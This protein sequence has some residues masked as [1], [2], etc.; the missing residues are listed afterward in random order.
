M[1]APKFTIVPIDGDEEIVHLRPAQQ[2]AYEVDFDEPLFAD[3]E[4]VRMSKV[5]MLAWYA[6]G[7]PGKFKDWLDTLEAVE[8]ADQG[9]DQDDEGDGDSPT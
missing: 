6:A 7:K 4:D 3:D 5:Y 9:E 1:A 8:M 2:V